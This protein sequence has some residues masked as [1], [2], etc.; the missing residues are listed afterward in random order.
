MS[1]RVLAKIKRGKSSRMFRPVPLAAV[2]VSLL[3]SLLYRSNAIVPV[4]QLHPI[5]RIA[6]GSCS[7]P[8]V[9]DGIWHLIASFAPNQLILLGDQVY[10]DYEPESQWKRS[11][12]ANAEQLEEEYRKFRLQKGFQKLLLS[13]THQWVATIDDHD[14]GKNNGDKTYKYRNESIEI[15]QKYNSEHFDPFFESVDPVSGKVS[16]EKKSGVFSSHFFSFPSNISKRQINFAVVLLDA[17]SNKDPKGTTD[18][19]F[20]GE[21]QWRWLEQELFSKKMNEQDLILVGSGIQFLP[22]DKFVEENWGEFPQQRERLLSLLA[23]V[24]RRQNL[25][26]LSGDIHSAEINQVRCYPSDDRSHEPEEVRLVELTSSGLSHTFAQVTAR[27]RMRLFGTFLR[28]PA[29]IW[30]RS[31]V[32]VGRLFGLCYSWLYPAAFREEPAAHS[33]DQL[34]FALLD[35]REIHAHAG[36]EGDLAVVFSVV[37]Y[38]GETVVQKTF[39]LRPPRPVRGEAADFRCLPV[40]G[41]VS[42]L[43]VRRYRQVLL[44]ISAVLLVLSLGVVLLLLAVIRGLLFPRAPSQRPQKAE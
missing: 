6:F 40:R 22:D 25:L 24:G 16:R 28:S 42:P 43:R 34:H 31:R 38:R 15:F 41:A 14:Y 5:H 21:Q 12:G 11:S 4:E 19:D 9:G 36:G 3:G 2:L 8:N 39:P 1:N 17:R 7:N 29:E 32:Y 35:F 30:V 18:G 37:N 10:A 13:L 44:A 20:L 23:R 26:L 33:Y 27:W